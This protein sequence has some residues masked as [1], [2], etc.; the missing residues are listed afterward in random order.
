MEYS[1][2]EVGLTDLAY[3]VQNTVIF[4]HVRFVHK[5][6]LVNAPCV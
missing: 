1:L 3:E 5:L 4:S 2:D 6:R